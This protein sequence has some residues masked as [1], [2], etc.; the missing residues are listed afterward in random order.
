MSVPCECCVLSG[1]DFCYE[2]IIHLEE[3]YR[4]WCVVLCDLE[5]SWMRRPWPTLGSSKKNKQELLSNSL[6]RCASYFQFL[7]VHVSRNMFLSGDCKPP[8][9]MTWRRLK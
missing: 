5:T 7:V 3:F 8:P 4:L 1:K 2:L 9:H 6:W